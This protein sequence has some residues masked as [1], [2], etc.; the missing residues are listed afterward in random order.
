[1][2]SEYIS[3]CD[4]IINPAECRKEFC[5]LRMMDNLI[6]D[7]AELEDITSYPMATKVQQTLCLWKR[8]K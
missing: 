7:N 6:D 8:R 1:M 5:R 3:T 4:K 2:Y